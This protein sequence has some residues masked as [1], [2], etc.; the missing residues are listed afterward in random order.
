[1]DGKEV[2]MELGIMNQ[3]IDVKQRAFRLRKSYFKHA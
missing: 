2:T 3:N 1:M